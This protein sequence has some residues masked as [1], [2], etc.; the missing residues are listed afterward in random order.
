MRT[1][2]RKPARHGARRRRFRYPKGV[3]SAAGLGVINPS[4]VNI[5]VTPRTPMAEMIAIAA[6]DPDLTEKAKVAGPDDQFSRR[7]LL[8][9]RGAYAPRNFPSVGA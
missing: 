8:G 4:E 1:A 7:L 5:L 3:R 9:E 2:G 6:S